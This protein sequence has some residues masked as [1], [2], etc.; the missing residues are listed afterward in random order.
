MIKDGHNISKFSKETMTLGDD[1]YTCTGKESEILQKCY[2]LYDHYVGEDRV[3]PIKN[4]ALRII[5]KYKNT[6]YSYEFQPEYAAGNKKFPCVKAMNWIG[7]TASAQVIRGFVR[8]TPV[9]ESCALPLCISR[10]VIAPKF[11]PVQMKEDP[12]HGFRVCV[13]AL[14]NKC[15]KPYASTAVSH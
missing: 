15:L 9:V 12:D 10:L 7:K 4:G 3:F 2:S 1:V 14:I 6:S 5:T 11:A 8:S 13:N